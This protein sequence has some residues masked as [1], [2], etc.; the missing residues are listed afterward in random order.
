MIISPVNESLTTGIV[1]C[2]GR[3][4]LRKERDG[5]MNDE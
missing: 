5:G 4:G 3:M 2:V 1:E